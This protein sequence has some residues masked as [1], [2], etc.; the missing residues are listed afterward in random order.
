MMMVQ[1]YTTQHT[2]SPT[3]EMLIEWASN[4]VV[5]TIGKDCGPAPMLLKVHVSSLPNQKN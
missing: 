5:L 2:S 1:S 3:K 4:L